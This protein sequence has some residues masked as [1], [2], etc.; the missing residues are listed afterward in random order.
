VRRY[1]PSDESVKED[2]AYSVEEIQQ[3]LPVCDLRSK[4]L[5]LLMV[6]SG[7]RVG[8]THTM[9]IGDLAEIRY[10]NHYL[11]KVF[12]YARTRYKYLTFCAP[13]CFETIQKYLDYRERCGE[14]LKG[15]V[16]TI[17]QTL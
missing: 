10:G 1:F 16:H 9:Q 17:S 3:I 7:V 15:Q 8:A 4:A 5:I 14:E 12:P 2:R 6:S 11:Y 13:E